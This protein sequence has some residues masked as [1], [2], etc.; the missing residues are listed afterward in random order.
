MIG[1]REQRFQRDVQFASLNSTISG[2]FNLRKRSEPFLGK[3]VRLS[4]PRDGHPN[5][6]NT[7][8]LHAAL[9]EKF[10]IPSTPYMTTPYM[11]RQDVVSCLDMQ[12]VTI[13]LPTGW[14]GRCFAYDELD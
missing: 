6:L 12:P 3:A 13:F 11:A 14:R 7:S 5:F 8:V 4:Q 10:A 9:N 2:P 1:D